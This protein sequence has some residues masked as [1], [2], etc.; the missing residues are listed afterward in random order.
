MQRLYGYVPREDRRFARLSELVDGFADE[1]EKAFWAGTVQGLAQDGLLDFKNILVPTDWLL[2]ITASGRRWVESLRAQ[3]ADPASRRR[4]AAIGVL[5]VLADADPDGIAWTATSDVIDSGV[6]LS[7]E[8]LPADVIRRAAIYLQKEELIAGTGDSLEHAGSSNLRLTELGLRC[9]E[10][11]LSVDE[12]LERARKK[13]PTVQNIFSGQF[14]GSNIAASSTNFTQTLSSSGLV[15]DE[16][17][18]L[19]DAIAQA[20]PALNLPN[21]QEALV[22]RNIEGVRA[23]LQE[24]EPDASVVKTMMTR[25]AAAVGTAAGGALGLG[26]NLLVKYEMAKMGIPID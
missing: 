10:S 22:V 4:A 5:T 24:A 15:A 26:L 11:N 7:G 9:V 25:T 20:L 16:L 8:R 6:S 13:E 18:S 1:Q 19:I 23:E 2:E 21:D 3:R 12:F 14:T 17:T